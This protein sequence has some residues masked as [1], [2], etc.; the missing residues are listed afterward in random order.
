MNTQ[1]NTQKT[2]I[3]ALIISVFLAGPVQAQA[4]FLDILGPL[5]IKK[6][7]AKT[8]QAAEALLENEQVYLMASRPVKTPKTYKSTSKVYFVSVTGYSS[9]PDQTDHT[10]FITAS[11]IHVRDGVAAANFLPFGTVFRIP[12]IFGDKTF[13]VEDRMHSRYWMNIDLWFPER[14]LAKEFGRKV[15]KIEIV[16]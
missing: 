5:G 13:V 11:G 14:G 8:D 16:S 2:L 10:P 1:M 3:F 12:E 15:V 7:L 9:T 4:G 6:L